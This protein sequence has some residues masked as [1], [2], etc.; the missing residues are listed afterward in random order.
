MCDSCPTFIDAI[1]NDHFECLKHFRSYAS[2][3]K[4][5]CAYTAARGNLYFLLYFHRNGY[6]WDERTCSQ[7][8]LH[9][10]L[11]CLKFARENGC[12]WDETT[13]SNAAQGNYECL[14]YAHENGCPWNDMAYF[15]AMHHGGECFEYVK[16]NFHIDEGDRW[17]YER[18][19]QIEED[20]PEEEVGIYQTG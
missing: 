16:E 4:K 13:C 20:E 9:N 7:A 14:V 5:I 8:A 15:N 18:P 3:D 17:F 10:Q 2:T 1:N 19:G 12:P 6:W 11:E